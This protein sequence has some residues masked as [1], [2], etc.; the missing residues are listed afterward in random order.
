ME[1]F[2]STMEI[3]T[4]TPVHMSYGSHV[5]IGE[6][7][8]SNFNLTLVDDGEIHIGK[9]NEE[10]S[11]VLDLKTTGK[12][13]YE[14][15]YGED[16]DYANPKALTAEGNL[17]VYGGNINIYTENDGGEGLESKDTVY[18]KGGYIIIDVY[19]DA[20]NGKSHV[21]FDGGTLYANAR[22]NDAIDSNGTITINGGLLVAAGQTAPPE[23]VEPENEK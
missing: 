20:I 16:A 2:I 4:E 3:V 14:S 9:E 15:G 1:T 7:F 23:K 5:F 19:D 6:R 22:G 11:L 18:I 21:Q 10:N 8:Y 12:K 17:Y 13:F